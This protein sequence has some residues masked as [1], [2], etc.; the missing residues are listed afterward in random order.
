MSVKISSSLPIGDTN[1]L[2]A[3]SAQLCDNPEAV[4]VA[5]VLLD[6]SQITTNTDNGDVVPTARIRAIEPIAQTSDA[7]EMRRLI[8]RAYERRTG[9]VEL[10][11]EME[12]EMDNIDPESEGK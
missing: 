12:Q 10:P 5:V 8:R 11:L 2:T 1:G 6:C 4:H 7:N 9:K 3:I